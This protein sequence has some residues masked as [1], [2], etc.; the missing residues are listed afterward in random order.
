VESL[1]LEGEHIES[2]EL[3]SELELEVADEVEIDS[4]GEQFIFSK[5]DFGGSSVMFGCSSSKSRNNC[6][7]ASN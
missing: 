3:E 4:M 6:R 1:E 2:I 7:A 5:F